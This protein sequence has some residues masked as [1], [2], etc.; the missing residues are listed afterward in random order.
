MKIHPKKLFPDVDNH[1][2]LQH[3]QI[4]KK[5]LLNFC[6]LMLAEIQEIIGKQK[7]QPDWLKSSEVR[8]LLKISS[9]TL[10]NLRINGT[11][12]YTKIGSIIYYASA[13]IDKLLEANKVE[14]EVTLFNPK[15]LVR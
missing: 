14:A 13:D 9:G 1:E 4:T 7:K 6:N 5:D 11:L 10:Q 8:K 12:N 15:W 2:L 3:Q